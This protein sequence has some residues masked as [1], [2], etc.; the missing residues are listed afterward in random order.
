[1]QLRTGVLYVRNEMVWFS[2]V[3]NSFL[4]TAIYSGVNCLGLHVSGGAVD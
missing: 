2:I 3:S 1:M 4:A